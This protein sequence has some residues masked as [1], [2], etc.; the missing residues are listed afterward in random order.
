MMFDRRGLRL[1]D[2]MGMLRIAMPS[3]LRAFIC[4]DTWDE[5]LLEH[6]PKIPESPRILFGNPLGREYSSPGAGHREDIPRYF[7]HG[8]CDIH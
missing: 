4:I 3:I 7:P 6:L 8:S 1:G 2:L 5:C